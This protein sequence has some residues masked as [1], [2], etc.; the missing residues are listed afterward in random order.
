MTGPPAPDEHPG[1]GRTQKPRRARVW[2]VVVSALILFGLLGYLLKQQRSTPTADSGAE[3]PPR[4]SAPAPVP[5]ETKTQSAQRSA[6]R[7]RSTGNSADTRK[8]SQVRYAVTHKHRLRDCHGT[9]TFT[10][11]GLRFESDEPQDSFTVR[12]DDVIVDGDALRIRDKMWRF[13]FDDAIR[14]ERVFKDW[15]N[16][17]LRSVSPA[18]P[19]R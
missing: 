2:A 12:L 5:P 18:S 1:D 15:K 8:P 17:T 3:S 13:E 10:R 19:K 14:A 7:G 6:T 9:L 11:D 16:G 4:E